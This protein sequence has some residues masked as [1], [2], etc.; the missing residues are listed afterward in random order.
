[1]KKEQQSQN[2]SLKDSPHS[3]FRNN[4]NPKQIFLLH[5]KLITQGEKC[6][7]RPKTCNETM[8]C[9]KLR[10]F[11]SRTLLPLKAV[12]LWISLPCMLRVPFSG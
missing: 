11:V 7:H 1:M 9:D 4:F 10:V 6:Q 2:L 8:L 3:T 12:L 5:N